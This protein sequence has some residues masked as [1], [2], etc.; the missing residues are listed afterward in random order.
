MPLK[1]RRE[2]LPQI[3]E[4]RH[5]EPFFVEYAKATLEPARLVPLLSPNRVREVHG[6]WKM[7]LKRVGDHERNLD[8][9]LDHFKQSG[10]LSFWVR[11]MSPLV[12]ARDPLTSREAVRDDLSEQQ[13]AFR[14][15]LYAYGNEYLAFDLGF[16]F[17]RFYETDGSGK[18][19][20][21][22]LSLSEEYYRTM[23]HFLKYKTVSP[24]AM[25]LIYKSLFLA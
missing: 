10:H 4:W 19:R 15:L 14:D 5:F 24:H 25:F 17:C 8:D 16:Q 7:D 12:E 2:T 9:G 6:A 13:I 11:R 18:C 1:I 20:A 23:C 22:T 3:V 21:D